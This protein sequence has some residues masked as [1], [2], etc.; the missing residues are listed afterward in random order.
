MVIAESSNP[1]LVSRKMAVSGDIVEAVEDLGSEERVRARPRK[2][3]TGATYIAFCRIL[4]KA[5]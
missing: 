4:G 3:P 5:L 2:K 1:H